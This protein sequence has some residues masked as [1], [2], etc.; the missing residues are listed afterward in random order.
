MH[1]S[2]MWWVNETKPDHPARVLEVGSLN[3]NGSVRPL[4]GN[5]DYTGV[6]RVAGPNVDMVLDA[7]ALETVF[8]DMTF[9]CVVCTE[10]LEHDTQP[11]RSLAQMHRVTAPFGC[12][13]VTARGFDERGAFHFHEYPADLWRFS[14]EGFTNL[15]VFAGWSPERVI[16]DPTDPGVF[17]LARRLKRDAHRS[18]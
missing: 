5:A 17:A 13:I 3:V 8:D 14:V 11:W 16:R 18:S 12:L 7:H 4:F 6:D 15:L 1:Q 10:M 9:D 2:V